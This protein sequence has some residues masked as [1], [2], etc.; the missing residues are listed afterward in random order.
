MNRNTV[1]NARRY[2]FHHPDDNPLLGIEL[3][4]PRA[5]ELTDRAQFDATLQGLFGYN[6]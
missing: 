2:L 3:P 5:E 4:P 1:L 6:R